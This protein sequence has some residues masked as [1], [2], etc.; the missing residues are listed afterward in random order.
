MFVIAKLMY[1]FFKMHNSLKIV[2]KKSLE[3]HPFFIIIAN[4]ISLI[5]FIA[6]A[7]PLQWS[8][9]KDLHFVTKKE[10]LN[11]NLKKMLAYLFTDDLIF[12]DLPSGVDTIKKMAMNE[13]KIS[14][15][16]HPEGKINKGVG[17][18]KFSNGACYIA[19]KTKLPIFPVCISGSSKAFPLDDFRITRHPIKVIFDNPFYCLNETKLNT[20]EFLNEMTEKLRS[21]LF[22]MIESSK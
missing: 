21:K 1:F 19:S 7:C 18:L 5:D 8:Q 10:N 6:I 16:I 3:G 20:S 2:N 13:Q 15:F 12:V 14:L 17:L 11:S 4:H 22:K 9:F